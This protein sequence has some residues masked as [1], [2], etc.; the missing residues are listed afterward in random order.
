[1][2]A[3][4]SPVEMFNEL[5]RQGYVVPAAIDPSGSMVPTAYVNVP[6]RTTFSTPVVL[7]SPEKR[8]RTNAKL[9]DR[10]KRNTKGNKRRK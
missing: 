6:T 8:E 10:S 1:M 9:G 3:K 7:G 2:S 4:M 5:I